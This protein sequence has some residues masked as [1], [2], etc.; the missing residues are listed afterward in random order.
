MLELFGIEGVTQVNKG[1]SKITEFRTIL[2]KES[3]NS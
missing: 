3:Q 2:Q 1:N